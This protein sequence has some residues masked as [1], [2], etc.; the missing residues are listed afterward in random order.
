MD[1]RT[2]EIYTDDGNIARVLTEHWQQAFNAKRTDRELR[3]HWLA[4]MTQRM[5]ITLDDLRP[6]LGDVE[7][8]FSN[9]PK[10]AP[11]PDGIPFCAYGRFKELLI[12]VFFRDLSRHAEWYRFAA[13]R[14]QL[15]FPLMS[16]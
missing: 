14:V 15:S 4:R 9:L 13:R 7:Y 10:S 6:T 1:P 16:S 2:T 3:H 5:D 11:G 12:P 8:V